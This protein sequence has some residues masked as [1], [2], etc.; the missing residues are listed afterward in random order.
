MQSYCQPTVLVDAESCVQACDVFAWVKKL[1]QRL[2]GLSETL[3]APQR[4]WQIIST[5]NVDLPL[6]HR[7][8]AVFVLMDLSMQA[9]IFAPLKQLP[10]ASQIAHLS[11]QY[12]FHCHSLPDRGPSSLPDSGTGVQAC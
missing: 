3:P 10:T 6:S 5:F 8:T 1:T 2:Q 7:H 12:V 9:A 4:L 11:L